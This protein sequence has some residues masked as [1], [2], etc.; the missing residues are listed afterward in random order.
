M[1]QLMLLAIRVY[2]YAISPMMAGHCRYFPSCSEYAQEAIT[3]H[4]ARRGIWLSTKRLCRCHP[5]GGHGYDPVPGTSDP[6]WE[7]HCQDTMTPSKNANQ[8]TP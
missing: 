1:R 5:W 2:R 8:T 3:R 4:G 7:N 6:S